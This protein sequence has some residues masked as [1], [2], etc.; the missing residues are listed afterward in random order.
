MASGM[1]LAHL[2]PFFH[3]I[4][5]IDAETEFVLR[6]SRGTRRRSSSPEQKNAQERQRYA[7]FVQALDDFK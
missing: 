5:D 7:E 1:S 3:S 2:A 6:C 4:H